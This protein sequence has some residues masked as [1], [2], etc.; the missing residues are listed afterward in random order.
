MVC[1]ACRVVGLMALGDDAV[2][3]R[4]PGPPD[5]QMHRR[6]LG[7][8]S[9]LGHRGNGAGQ[10]RGHVP[11]AQLRDGRRQT[12]K[13]TGVP[14]EASGYRMQRVSEAFSKAL[15]G[16]EVLTDGSALY[17]DLKSRQPELRS[18]Q[19][20][21]QNPAH[22]KDLALTLGPKKL[23]EFFHFT[24]SASEIAS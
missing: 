17:P 9:S 1:S 10:G 13:L 23:M 21:H 11:P 16:T 24:F 20:W 3:L 6:S 19:S 12:D 7:S 4:S 8:G 15:G 5:Y 2:S 22:R 18:I 14:V